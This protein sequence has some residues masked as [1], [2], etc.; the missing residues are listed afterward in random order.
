MPDQIADEAN[1]AIEKYGLRAIAEKEG[2][3]YALSCAFY[4]GQFESLDRLER[5]MVESAAQTRES[6]SS[7][8]DALRRVQAGETVNGVRLGL[9][10]VSLEWVSAAIAHREAGL[11]RDGERESSA[12]DL[13]YRL[14]GHVR[15]DEEI[16][17]V[18]WGLAGMRL[19]E[20]VRLLDPAR[21]ER[22]TGPR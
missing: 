4:V 18:T 9:P 20:E 16:P 8:L 1:N 3:E 15:N 14:A 11:K 22:E 10:G 7:E 12:L 13:L 5:D 17:P 19:L 2:V 6:I 21:Y